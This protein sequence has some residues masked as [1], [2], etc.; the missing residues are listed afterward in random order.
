MI[1]KVL[2]WIRRKK[3]FHCKSFCPS[4]RYY[5]ECVENEQ[6]VSAYESDSYHQSH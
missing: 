1:R 4:C 2:F 5:Q 6:E 3:S